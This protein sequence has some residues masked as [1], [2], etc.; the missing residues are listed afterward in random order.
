VAL[1]SPAIHWSG[2]G[3]CD[4]NSGDAPLEDAFD[5][6]HWSR[7]SVRDGTV[8]LYDVRSRSGEER[9][10]AL[11]YDPAGNVRTFAP[12]PRV[13]LPSSRWRIARDTRADAGHDATVLRTLTD[14]PFYARSLVASQLLGE[15]VTAMH[16]SL[17]LD[18]F[19]TPWVRML[20]PFRMPRVSNA[21]RAE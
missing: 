5:S 1:A 18:R 16:E 6:W 12:P 10:H 8:V 4:T 11:H 9:S 2:T 14:A 17:S 19:R 3:Y 13:A 7:M 21:G 20:L 15:P